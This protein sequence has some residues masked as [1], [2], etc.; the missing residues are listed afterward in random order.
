[1]R[2]I[3]RLACHDGIDVQLDVVIVELLV[4]SRHS[5]AKGDVVAHLPTRPATHCAITHADTPLAGELLEEWAPP[6][7]GAAPGGRER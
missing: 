7:G 3:L 4:P 6:G 2:R 5:L 1:M